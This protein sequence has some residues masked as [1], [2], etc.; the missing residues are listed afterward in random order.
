MLSRYLSSPT[1]PFSML[2]TLRNSTETL[3]NGIILQHIQKTHGVLTPTNHDQS[4]VRAEAVLET[5]VA[6]SCC[7]MLL[8]M[9][10]WRHGAMLR[11]PQNT[12]AHHRLPGSAAEGDRRVFGLAEGDRRVFGIS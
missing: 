1:F 6:C 12:S 4:R 7:T 5:P 2:S 10:L 9:G 11:N 3:P 8:A